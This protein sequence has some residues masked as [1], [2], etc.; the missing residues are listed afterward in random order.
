MADLLAIGSSGVLAH[1]TLLSTTSNNISNVSTE[2][3]SRQT[4]QVYTNNINQ[5]CGRTETTR[6]INV[7][8]QRELLRDNASV[9]Y[10]D[11]VKTTLSNIDSLLSNSSTGLSGSITD[12]F[13]CV[14]S[15]NTNP[16]SIANRNELLGS[17]QSFSNR[18]NTLSQN[19]QQEYLSTNQKIEETV[20]TINQLLDG[21]YTMNQQ[22][23][24][25]HGQANSSSYLQMKDERDA[26]VSE[27]STYLD[28]KTV[29]QEKGGVLVNLSSGQ[30]LILNDGCAK[31]DI[32]VASLDDTEYGLSFSYGGG[33][34]TLK[35]DVGGKLGG[36]FDACESLK[37]KQRDLGKIA[38]ALAD[39][40][41]MQNKG[42][43]TLENKVGGN[44][45]NLPTQIVTS[46]SKTATMTMDFIPGKATN[47]SG[48][49][50]LVA[51]GDSNQYTI[52]EKFDGEYVE[53]DIGTVAG[54]TLNFEDFGFS[55]KI[56]GTVS[57]GDQFLVQP[58]MDIGY[59]LDVA[60]TH[61]EQFA[62]ASVIRGT[63]SSQNQG[64]AQILING[65]TNTD[66]NSAFNIDAQSNITFKDTAP[67]KVS[68]NSDG[69][70]VVYDKNNNVLGTAAN[71]T[72]GKNILSNLVD[73]NGDLIFT[74]VS[75]FP[76]YDFCISGTIKSGDTFSIDLNMNGFADNSNGIL[77]QDLEQ[78]KLVQ[79]DMYRTF[80]ES[81]S[82]LVSDIGTEIKVA[83]INHDAAVAKQDQTIAITES[84]KG[85]NL[86]E[87][88]SNLVRYQQCYTASAKIISAAQTIFDALLSAVG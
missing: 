67:T 84:S 79:G 64:N 18:V 47:I 7:Y 39:A 33:Y 77:M 49:D 24:K 82:A 2:G 27:L 66:I 75:N 59:T 41:N 86:D 29:E 38:V 42:G 43:L 55:L 87:E 35:T 1:Q 85:V 25:G 12:L 81:Y 51:I 23:S 37:D 14:Q 53:R 21:I 74:D 3:Y 10:Y 32:T 69:D 40:V 50:Y 63:Q 73:A 88:A 65:V 28:I 22:I 15:A 5:G 70:Y 19:I 30:T 13:A 17:V 6:C 54:D 80:T 46:T 31:L 57:K 16:T 60:V 76:G 9:G 58:T 71:A 4:T 83:T 68:V 78:G 72:N 45:F 20:Q 62:F 56:N 44:V 8:A 26:L 36:Y 61:P 11:T 34:T 52:Y 48:N